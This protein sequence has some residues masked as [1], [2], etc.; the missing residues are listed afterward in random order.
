MS[1]T[2]KLNAEQQR[3]EAQRQG[4]EDW[5]LWG[6]YLSERAWGT[7]REDYSPNGTAWEYFDHEQARSRTY[8]WN[9]DGL[10]GISDQQQ[11]L[12]F[13]LAL[14]NGHDPILKERLFGLTGN[15]GNHGEDVKEYY[16]YQDASPSHSY[17]EYLYK[18]PQQAFPYEDL[19]RENA[20][21]T[22][23]QP[24]FNL[25][26][27]GIF[28]G[29]RYWDVSVTYAKKST[30]Q[31]HIRISV[32][33][34]SHQ[35]ETLSVLPTLWFRNTWSWGDPVDKPLLRSIAPP[36]GAAWA[37]QCE[38]ENLGQYYLY[39]AT[40]AELLFTENESNSEKLWGIDNPSPYVKDAF[41]RYLIHCEDDA[42]NPEQQGTKAAADF[43]LDVPAGQT[44]AVDLLLSAAALV[45]PFEQQDAV[46]LIRQHETDQFYRERLP[47][48]NDE[49]R[50]IM[51]QAL[52]G[53]IWN[54]QFYHYDVLRWFQGDGNP[55]P[56]QRKRGRNQQWRH[57]K[58]ADIVSMPDC[59]EYPWFAAWDL[60]YHCA[61]LALIDVDFAK[62]QIELMLH[63]NYLHPNG[64]IPAYEW[65][66]G[67]VN[68]PVH[69]MATLKVFR[70]E[71][72]QRK[73]GDLSFLQ[74]VFHK[75]LLNYAWWINRKDQDGHNIFE[76][77]FLGLDNIS[78]YDR[79]QPLEP[80]YILK[81]A[82]ATGWMAMFT[83][84]M[85]A[86]ALEIATEDAD[87][88]NI[89]IQCY[90]QFLAIASAIVG[91][92][93]H[94]LSLWD[95]EAGFFKD[96]VIAP[97]G[98]GH[99]LDVYS[100]V[101]LIPLFACEVIDQ[102]MLK[103]VPR[104]RQLL[105]EHKGGLFR[106]E[107]IC[108]CPDWENERGEH[109]LALVDHSMLPRIL[110]RVLD[111]DQFLS[112]YGV[113]SVSRV[114]AETTDLGFIPGIGQ[115]SIRYIPG[116]SESWLFG[117][118]SNWRGPVWM[119]TNYSLIQALEKFYR[120]L[121]P[122]LKI[123]VPC[124]DNQELNLN[125]IATLLSERLVNLYRHDEQGHCP[126]LRGDSPFQHM[127]DWHDLRLFYEY[128][129]AETGQGL[130]AAH[131]TGWTGLIANLVMRRYRRSIPNYWVDSH[132]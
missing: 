60:G 62:D 17:L 114:H 65:A 127:T 109:L 92:D 1:E 83:L 50:L 132:E 94:G 27:S 110:K 59:W 95:M 40:S 51:R 131:Q 118:N 122:G 103:N 128:F 28:S 113:R 101:G 93:E 86:I 80:G 48:G 72:V 76:G 3:L 21:R 97:D 77:G 5:R 130:G 85:T 124:Q 121:G 82:D 49:D 45:E 19:I 56:E 129:H 96:A 78:V 106:G 69:A 11:Q 46:F 10:A 24:P 116:E 47:E 16:F 115:A 9:E 53:M 26:D 54:K 88:E 73:Q 91:G 25:L 13:A 44:V 14:W 2:Q 61:A 81:Q 126:A 63:E 123:P 18:Y 22:R 125:E 58:A 107:Y 33:N 37:I 74:R 117:G 108:A 84:N 104:F 31:I 8:R 100:W 98:Q 87:Y 111:E 34:H 68:P 30:E 90:Q 20:A 29:N 66:F 75:L 71:R 36:S 35:A 102:R 23:E 52:A 79:S 42:V 43:R 112:P 39:G 67:D 4:T 64:Q 7:V 57:L 12:C 120:F 89:A 15:Q 6:P 99:Y 32:T 119:P 105:H 55:P 70:A 38:H 41:H